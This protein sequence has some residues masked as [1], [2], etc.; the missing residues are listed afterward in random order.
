MAQT[1]IVRSTDG[2]RPPFLNVSPLE[3]TKTRPIP[4]G[5]RDI[6]ATTEKQSECCQ[7][8]HFVYLQVEFIGAGASTETGAPEEINP[9]SEVVGENIPNAEVAEEI[10]PN[11]ET[12]AA[13]ES[14]PTPVDAT[15]PTPDENVTGTSDGLTEATS[16]DQATAP[17]VESTASTVRNPITTQVA[18]M[19]VKVQ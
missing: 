16:F 4:A 9:N 2:G 11:T 3:I 13:T 18:S 10:N 7:M 6:P 15:R 5:Q 14:D 1:K 17:T 8:F 12:N 19:S